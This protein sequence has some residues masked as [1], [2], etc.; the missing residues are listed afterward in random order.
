MNGGFV[1]PWGGDTVRIND[2]FFKGGNS[3]RGFEVAGIGPRIVTRDAE[4]GELHRGDALGGRLYAVG[5]FEV[6]FPTGL[7]EQYGVRASVFTE[8]G[9]LGLLDSPDQIDEGTAG[10]AFTIDDMALRA[11]AGVSIFWDSPFGPVRFDFAEAF[12]REDYDRAEFFRFST[13]TGF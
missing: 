6:S 12:I 9:T 5:A 4:T 13:R 11:S 3:F 10:T 7:P 1:Q 2:R 8:F